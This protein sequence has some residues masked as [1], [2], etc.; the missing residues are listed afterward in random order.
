M[1]WIFLYGI[2][3]FFISIKYYMEVIM[4]KKLHK[5]VEESTHWDNNPPTTHADMVKYIDYKIRNLEYN[6]KA[7]I[8]R[9]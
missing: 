6:V 8:I 2:T 1:I 7:W 4:D 3:L 9:D 5:L